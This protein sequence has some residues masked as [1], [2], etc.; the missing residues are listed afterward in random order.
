MICLIKYTV[1]LSNG[2]NVFIFGPNRSRN[3]PQRVN[4][5]GTLRNTEITLSFSSPVDYYRPI[6]KPSSSKPHPVIYN[7]S[8]DGSRWIYIGEETVILLLV[9]MMTPATGQSSATLYLNI[10][11]SVI[12]ECGRSSVNLMTNLGDII[13]H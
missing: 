2:T 12:P 8:T 5:R 4:T 13:L 10:N 7:Y 11:L 9:S 3:T 1:L 6:L